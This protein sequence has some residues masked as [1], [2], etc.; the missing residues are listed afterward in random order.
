MNILLLGPQGSGKGTQAGLLIEKFGFL[1]LSSGDILRK[2]AETDSGLKERLNNGTFIPDE[3]TFGILRQYLEERSTFDNVLMD[4][5]PRSIKQYELF[6]NWLSGKGTKIDLVLVLKISEEETIKRLSARRMD[7]KT[8]KIYNLIT[9]PPGSDVDLESL[10]QRDD[11][12]SE[13]IKKRLDW[14]KNIV[15]PLLKH[16]RKEVKIVEVD[17]ERPISIIFEDLAKIVEGVKSQ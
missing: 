13:S 1:S 5:F 7:P 8:G 9:D 12:T 15:E 3:E 10:I 2:R 17:G 14:Y 16:M 4:G 6:K 11:D